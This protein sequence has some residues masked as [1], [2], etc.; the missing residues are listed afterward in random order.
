MARETLVLLP[1]A[2]TD[3]ELWD[4]QIRSLG[5]LVDPLPIALNG[6]DTVAAMAERVLRTAPLRFNLAG[7]SLGGH[8]ALE[9]MRRAPQRVLRLAL[10][11]F[12]ARPEP[13][14][15]GSL[16]QRWA[17]QV[18]SGQYEAVVEAL[19]PALIAPTTGAG[20]A[21]PARL[22]AMASRCGAGGFLALNQA[23]L[24]RA[25]S[26]PTLAAIACPTLVI[27]GREDHAVPLEQAE[28]VAAGIGHARLMV[29]EGCGHLAPLEQPRA[30]TRALRVWL[31]EPIAG[32]S[33]SASDARGPIR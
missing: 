24:T 6:A 3:A 22:R 28:E 25:D 21:L 1:G 4:D 30:V 32:V 2:F 27:A 5:D 33:A 7:V 8:V 16:R 26:R 17:E 20:A 31:A 13:P 15:K 9:I 11:N 18:K 29:L 10:L 14:E 12:H 19:I 23:M